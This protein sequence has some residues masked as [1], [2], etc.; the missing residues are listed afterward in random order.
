MVLP[1]WWQ[2]SSDSWRGEF[3]TSISASTVIICWYMSKKIILSFLF[4]ILIVSLVFY[5]G[6]NRHPVNQTRINEKITVAVSF[7]PIQYFTQKVVGDVA[8]VIVITP[9]GVEPHDFEPTPKDIIRLRQSK[10]FFYN[11][12]GVD[13][14]ADRTRDGLIKNGVTVVALNQAVSLENNDPHIWLDPIRV[15]QEVALIR[16][17][18]VS[19]DPTHADAYRANAEKYSEELK[20][21]DQDYR[22]GLAN[23]QT[24]DIVVSHDAFHYPA[25]RYHLNL[26]AIARFSPDAEP[27]AQRLAELSDLIKEKHIS[28]IFF[29]T[30]ATPKLAETLARETQVKT[31][32]LNPIEGLTADN[33]KTGKNYDILMQDNLTVLRTALVCQ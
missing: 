23:C 31:A 27:S 19:I 24:R 26:N 2:A 28:T 33:Q 1:P 12:V 14:W 25:A 9:S 20:K 4:F 21:L 10:V 17:T 5:F 30:L 18:L 16:D 15:A 6:K 3:K 11:G 13:A 29:E 8:N 32:I 22:T 7:Y